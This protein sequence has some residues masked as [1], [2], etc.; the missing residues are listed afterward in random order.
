MPG[1][2]LPPDLEA[3]LAR[4]AEASG[5]STAECFAAAVKQFLKTDASTPGMQPC[6]LSD[7]EQERALSRV[8]EIMNDLGKLP[9]QD[10][11]HPNDILYD[12]HGLPL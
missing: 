6:P 1:I 8:R 4:I 11:R 7:L 10:V 5:L 3:Q 2:E 9:I 12:Q